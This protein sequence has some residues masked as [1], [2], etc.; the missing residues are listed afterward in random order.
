MTKLKD[1]KGLF[2]KKSHKMQNIIILLC[3]MG[4]L[5]HI[6]DQGTSST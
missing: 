2:L 5:L 6:I 1:L 3:G 4:F